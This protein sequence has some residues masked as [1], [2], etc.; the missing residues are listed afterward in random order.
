MSETKQK[1]PMETQDQVVEVSMKHILLSLGGLILSTG[2]VAASVILVKDYVK[3]RRQKAIVESAM[4]VLLILKGENNWNDKK[5]A[6]LFPT[7]K[8]TKQEKSSDTLE[9]A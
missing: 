1:L 9:S 5:T 3:Y 8:L 6:S 4:K 7:K 2:I